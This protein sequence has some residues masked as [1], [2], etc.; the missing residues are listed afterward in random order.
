MNINTPQLTSKLAKATA[1]KEAP[2][3]FFRAYFFL[4]PSRKAREAAAATTTPSATTGVPLR[5][6]RK[7][8]LRPSALEPRV[9]ISPEAVKL[10][11]L[12]LVPQH[13][14]GPGDHLE[15]LVGALVSVLVRMR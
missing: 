6:P 11:P 1:A 13:T 4:E 14:K 8:V 2:E 10:F 9:R 3:H 12:L 5:K 7:R 15:R